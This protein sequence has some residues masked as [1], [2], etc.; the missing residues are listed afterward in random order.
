MNVC[1][2]PTTNS[3]M[4]YRVVSTVRNLSDDQWSSL[5]M[6][7]LLPPHFT[8]LLHTYKVFMRVQDDDACMQWTSNV[9]DLPSLSVS[10]ECRSCPKSFSFKV[11]LLELVGDNSSA[12]T[13]RCGESAV[14]SHAGARTVTL[15]T[16]YVLRLRFVPRDSLPADANY[17]LVLAPSILRLEHASI[18]KTNG[19][20]DN[21][22]ASQNGN[23]AN[24]C[25]VTTLFSRPLLLPYPIPDNSMPFNVM[26]LVSFCCSEVFGAAM[27]A[28]SDSFLALETFPLA[29]QRAVRLRRRIDA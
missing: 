21:I 18:C 26:T 23:G 14:P 22:S 9:A 19:F 29:D 5:R 11:N 27:V 3:A 28:S 13:T 12:N 15:T 6:T 10:S 20:V 25:R 24:T 16:E 4:E 8:M 17:G 7:E 1:L 2:V